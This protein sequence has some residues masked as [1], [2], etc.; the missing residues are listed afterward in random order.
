KALK[1]SIDYVAEGQLRNVSAEN[2]WATIEKLAQ[3]EDEEWKDPVIPEKGNLDYENLDI[4]HLLGVMEYKVD[5]LMKDALWLMGGSENIFIMIS[6]KTYRL[7]QNHHV[8]EEDEEDDEANEAAGGDADNERARGFVDM[9][10]KMSQGDWH[11]RQARWM[12]QQD[13]HWGRFNT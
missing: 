3:Y 11:F 12:D 10:R 7:P 2:A 8:D 13:E 9:Y 1:E 4:E 5:T 6:N